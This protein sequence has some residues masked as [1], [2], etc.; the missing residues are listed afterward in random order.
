V[1]NPLTKT[2]ISDTDSGSNPPQQ[3]HG[4]SPGIKSRWVQRCKSFTKVG[5]RR[6]FAKLLWTLVLTQLA[7]PTAVTEIF[8]SSSRNSCFDQWRVQTAIRGMHLPLHFYP[9]KITPPPV[10]SYV[11]QIVTARSDFLTQNALDVEIY[12]IACW[13]WVQM[14][15][16]CV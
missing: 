10:T 7:V 16:M 4:V 5:V 14:T 11:W 15:W 3:F 13:I 1:L 6:P 12:A 8:V 9:L 2:N